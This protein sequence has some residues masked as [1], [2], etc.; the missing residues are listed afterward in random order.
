MQQ[1]KNLWGISST[2]RPIWRWYKIYFV[3]PSINK[4]Q[5]E[6]EVMEWDSIGVNTIKRPKRVIISLTTYPKRINMVCYTLLSLFKQQTKADEIIL[7]LA[8]E[9]F[10][11]GESDLPLR[12]RQ[13]QKYGLKIKWCSNIYSYKKLIPSLLMFPEDIIVTV[14]D[15]VYYSPKFL[16]YLLSNYNN[17]KNCI[18]AGRAH[19]I[20]C[21]AN[22]VSPYTKWKKEIIMA[23]PSFN[24]FFTGV[25]GVLYP[26]YTLHPDVFN[27]EKFQRLCPTGD[28]IWFWAMA[29]L[30]GTKI[31]TLEKHLQLF[32]Y[33]EPK[34]EAKGINTL[35]S[36][37]VGEDRN[38]V[39]I[40]NVLQA[41]PEILYK[42]NK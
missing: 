33:I 22:K 5:I 30:K 16:Q 1:L 6:K 23:S 7:W 8:K 25:G 11:A 19:Y 40:A 4:K 26:P 38:D 35:N 37:N 41:Y 36:I 14:D 42:L 2:L 18:I 9:E 32:K 10:P 21:I 15:D 31:S 20:K 34:L 28:D 17:K 39:Q 12:L 24:V 13:M 27:I 3:I 29:V